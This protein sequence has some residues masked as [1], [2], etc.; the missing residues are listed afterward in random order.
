MSGLDKEVAEGRVEAEARRAAFLAA[1]PKSLLDREDAIAGVARENASARSKLK[2]VYRLMDEISVYRAGHVACGRACSACCRMN[3]TISGLEADA[4]AA[5]TGRSLRQVTETIAHPQDEFVGSP[6][7]FLVADEC[8]IYDS[9][10][11][12]CRKHASYFSTNKWCS[13]PH[14]NTIQAP[15]VRFG[16]LDE[17]LVALSARRGTAIFADIRDFF[18]PTA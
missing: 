18:E 4:I 7:S 9:R 17:A 5:A 11:L 16:G 12:A 3:V 8:S 10:P 15:L 2:R 14:L 13:P 6:C 1:V